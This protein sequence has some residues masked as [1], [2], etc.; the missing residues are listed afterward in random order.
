MIGFIGSVFTMLFV[1][2]LNLLVG[3]SDI[4]FIIFTSTIVDTLNLAFSLMPAM[5]LFARV[6][7]NHIEATIFAF[8]TSINNLNGVVS[9][10]VGVLINNLFVGVDQNNLEKV[11]ILIAISCVTTLIPLT[12]VKLVP[13]KSEM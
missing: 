6:T 10:N 7:P 2:R 3:I 1:L 5:V 11:Y 9:S 8:L 12:F 4:V 13:L